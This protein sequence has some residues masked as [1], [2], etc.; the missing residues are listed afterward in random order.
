M[1]RI[2][3]V[4]TPTLPFFNALH[5]AAS[6]SLY[7]EATSGTPIPF[8]YLDV[9]QGVQSYLQPVIDYA[10]RDARGAVMLTGHSLGGGLAK[11]IAAVL[12]TEAVA[13]EGPG[14]VNP[15]LGLFYRKPWGRP[16]TFNGNV[17]VRASGDM[18]GWMGTDIGDTQDVACDG[19]PRLP[20]VSCHLTVASV[21][22]HNCGGEAATRFANPP[23]DDRGYDK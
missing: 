16:S 14:V 15:F 11:A 12:G 5:S 17:N 7:Q 19:F 4:L 6:T 18:V 23:G 22:L 3:F 8:W 20:L 21:L 2:E 9:S 10:N 13:F 1:G